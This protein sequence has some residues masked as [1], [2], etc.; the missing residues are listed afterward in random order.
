MSKFD[1]R[2]FDIRYSRLFR[3]YAPEVSSGLWSP[4]GLAS[5]DAQC[6]RDADQAGLGGTFLAALATASQPTAARFD[7]SGPSW[8][9][10]DGA[11]VAPIAAGIFDDT[12][13]ATFVDRRAD[14]AP[15]PPNARWWAGAPRAPGI[16]GCS[17]WTS[18]SI[19]VQG[20]IGVVAGTAHGRVFQET[21]ASCNVPE[22]L[23]CLQR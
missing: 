3:P 8:V 22:H 4:A 11:V 21:S 16:G 12:A 9:R 13:L 18:S 6:Q 17:N 14:G 10:P 15:A 1:L 2:L 5:A 19:A 23:L 20:P 7:L